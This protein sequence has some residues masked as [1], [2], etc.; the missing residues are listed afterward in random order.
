MNEDKIIEDFNNFLKNKEIF[1]KYSIN[2]KT[3]KE[4]MNKRYSVEELEV[5]KLER[6]HQRN[7][8]RKAKYYNLYHTDEEYRKLKRKK[9]LIFYYIKRHE[10]NRQLKNK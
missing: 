10:Y 9:A 2:K 4:I 3:L 8:A 6:S 7:E 1:K 5:F